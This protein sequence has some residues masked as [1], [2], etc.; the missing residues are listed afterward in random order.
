[1]AFLFKISRRLFAAFAILGLAGAAFT[2]PAH[3]AFQG[4]FTDLAGRTVVIEKTPERFVVANYIANFMMTGG[5]KSLGKVVG[6]TQDGWEQTRQGEYRVFTKAFPSITM[7]PSIGGYHDNI[8]NAERILS[9]KPDVL[10]IGRAQYVD[11]SGRIELFEKAGIRVVVLDYHAMKPENHVKS[12]DIL[13]KLLDR[14]EAAAAQNARYTEVLADIRGRIAA[15][16]EEK[17]HRRVYVELGNEGVGKYGNS[18]NSTVLWGG[19]LKNLD[20]ANI[21]ADMKTPYGPLDREF[22]VAS[23][24]QTVV[25]GGSIWQNAAE[26]DQMRMGLTVDEATAQLRLKGFSERPLWQKMEAVKTGEVYGVDHGSL[27]CMLDYTF[28]MY[29]AKVLYP[30]TFADYDPQKEIASFYQTWL[31]EVEANGTFFVK[32]AQ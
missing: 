2:G 27:R 28:S 5:A 1:M 14:E 31:P 20:A 17:K 22:V 30:E 23:N 13:G 8:L 6:M 10:L 29:L 24:P 21:A 26:G 4:E 15:L 25:I 9:L 18:Y 3:A 19:I 32:L 7:L 11:N 16:P 12:T